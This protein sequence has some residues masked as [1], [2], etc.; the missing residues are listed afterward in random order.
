MGK[1]LEVQSCANP[2]LKSNWFLNEA[3]T[4]CARCLDLLIPLCDI[5]GRLREGWKGGVRGELGGHCAVKPSVSEPAD[6]LCCFSKTLC[7]QIQKVN[8]V[9]PQF[10]LFKHTSKR[11]AIK[12]RK[13]PSSDREMRPMT[14]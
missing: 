8:P 2:H 3:T 5:D 10:S 1:F 6:L 12:D 9:I 14:K 11:C 7:P 4:R 13:R